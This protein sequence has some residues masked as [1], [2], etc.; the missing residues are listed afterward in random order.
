MSLYFGTSSDQLERN[1]KKPKEVFV[2]HRPIYKKLSLKV[3]KLSRFSIYIWLFQAIFS[4]NSPDFPQNL[5]LLFW[6]YSTWVL[7]LETVFRYL[8]YY[9]CNESNGKKGGVFDNIGLDRDISYTSLSLEPLLISV[10]IFWK[11]YEGW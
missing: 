6:A 4:R 10:I 5:I 8:I 7:D 3:N 11:F 9:K 1:F 2:H